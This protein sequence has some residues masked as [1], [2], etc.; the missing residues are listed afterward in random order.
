[1]SAPRRKTWLES[2]PRSAG[3]GSLWLGIGLLM[4]VMLGFAFYTGQV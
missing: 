1:M 2:G 3:E 4:A